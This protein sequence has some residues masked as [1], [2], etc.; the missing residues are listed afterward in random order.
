MTR[1]TTPSRSPCGPDHR[2]VPRI[3]RGP[4][5]CTGSPTTSGD[6]RGPRRWRL[7]GLVCGN[8]TTRSARLRGAK[9]EGALSTRPPQAR[10]HN[11]YLDC[12]ASRRNKL[13]EEAGC[14]IGDIHCMTQGE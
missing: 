11:P 14:A 2:E 7:P 8:N 1:A 5:P 9:R 6:R 4:G 3:P 10:V 12:G 13:V